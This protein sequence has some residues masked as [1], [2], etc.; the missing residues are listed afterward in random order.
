MEEESNMKRARKAAEAAFLQLLKD[1][2]PADAAGTSAREYRDCQQQP[3]RNA[4]IGMRQDMSAHLAHKLSKS[5]VRYCMG[6]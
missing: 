1:N 6:L 2:T 3:T 5:T 4:C